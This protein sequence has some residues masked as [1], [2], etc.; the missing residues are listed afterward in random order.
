L[1]NTSANNNPNEPDPPL[2]QSATCLKNFDDEVR[3]LEHDGRL[4]QNRDRGISISSGSR[5]DDNRRS[6]RSSRSRSD[7]DDR[8][9]D[10][11]GRFMGGSSS[12]S[13]PRREK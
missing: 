9:R 10:E 8:D 11:Y 6:S 3:D 7:D 4:K 12:R 2:N 5:D 13:S 1:R